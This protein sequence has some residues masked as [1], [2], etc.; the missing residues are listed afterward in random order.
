[1]TCIVGAVV[2]SWVA[3]SSASIMKRDAR[4]ARDASLKERPVAKVVRLLQDMMEELDNE[5]ADDKAVHEKLECWCKDNGQEK[6]KAIRLGEGKE[7]EL[8][9]YL[10]EAAA[11]MKELEA[12]R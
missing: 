4:D 1:M 9:S 2:L 7:G 6:T 11:K 12:K 3:F 10:G 5:L 8:E